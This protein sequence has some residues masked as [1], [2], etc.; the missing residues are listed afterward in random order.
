ME[1]F[2]DEITKEVSIYFSLGIVFRD[3]VKH[4]DY[5]IKDI[6]KDTITLLHKPLFRSAQKNDLVVAYDEL[7]EVFSKGRFFIQGFS[8]TIEGGYKHDLDKLKRAVK[9]TR[10]RIELEEIRIVAEKLSLNK[11]ELEKAKTEAITARELAEQEKIKAQQTIESV[12]EKRKTANRVKL[13]A[14]EAAAAHSRKIKILT[15]KKSAMQQR[16]RIYKM[17]I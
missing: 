1:A 7:V 13:I 2:I 10:D 12:L 11:S 14:E 5:E 16:I 8:T 17:E 9:D 6:S 4:D 15:M 3:L